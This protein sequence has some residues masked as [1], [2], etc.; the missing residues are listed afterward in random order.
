VL[1]SGFEGCAPP[2]N[3]WP[4]PQ[5]FRHHEAVVHIA[6]HQWLVVLQAVEPGQ[7]TLEHGAGTLPIQLEKLLG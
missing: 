7:C 5:L 4:P 2:P 6:D 1:R 3:P